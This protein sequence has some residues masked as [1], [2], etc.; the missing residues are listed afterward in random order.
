MNKLKQ[1]WKQT[2]GTTQGDEVLLASA[3]RHKLRAPGL[4]PEQG[5]EENEE[6]RTAKAG[7]EDQR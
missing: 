4:R 6:V 7:E 1:G 2:D 3:K 5:E